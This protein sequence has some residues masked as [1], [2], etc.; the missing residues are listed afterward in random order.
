MPK[1]SY[2]F[3]LGETET[4]FQ[5]TLVDKFN[6]HNNMADHLKVLS[7]HLNDSRSISTDR[8]YF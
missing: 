5:D 8:I 7:F 1:K 2:D 6:L 3:L 4:D